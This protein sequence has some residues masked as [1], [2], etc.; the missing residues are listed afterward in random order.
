MLLATRQR[1]NDTCELDLLVDGTPIEKVSKQKLLGII[2]D[3]NLSWS[4]HIDYLCSTISTKISLLRQIST[5]VPQD[6]QKL[7]YHSYILPLLDYGSNTWGTTSNANIERLCKLQKRAARIILKAEYMTPSA[8]MFER[9]G[10]LSVPKRLMYNKAVLTY[11]ALNNLTPNYISSLLKPISETHV[12]SL[13]S[14][15]N[16][17]LSVPRSR[18]AL[19]DRS[20]S[21]SASKLWNSLP[22]PIRTTSSLNEFKTCIRNHF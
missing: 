6:I 1:V 14:S 18:T 22:K 11:K 15:E 21:H 19:F 13:R 7:F 12:L 20:F 2:I 17:L 4:Q 10:W 16:G 9:L 3:E 5:Y 8:H